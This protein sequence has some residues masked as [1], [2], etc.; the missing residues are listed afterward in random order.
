MEHRT[1]V[2]PQF[3][4]FTDLLVFFTDYCSVVPSRELHPTAYRLYM[5]LLKQLRDMLGHDV[6]SPNYEK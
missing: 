6:S 2:E 4:T 5:E 1:G 3:R